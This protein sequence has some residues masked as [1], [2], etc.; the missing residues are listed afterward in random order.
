MQKTVRDFVRAFDVCQRQKNEATSPG[1]FLQ[2][3]PIP[4]AIW[5]DISLDFIT[6]LPKS[7]GFEAVLVV[8][9]RLSKYSHFILMKHPYTAKSV[10]ELFVKEIV[11]L[12]GIPSSI[13]SDRDPLFVSHFWK[14]LFKMPG[15]TLKM[16]SSY[17]PE[18]YGQTEVTNRCLESYLRCFAAE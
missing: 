15:T 14:E 4:N 8:V 3:L 6:G 17:H 1:G 10:A 11:R 5:E 16:S 13:V 12:H 9:D 18:T 2:P 7:K